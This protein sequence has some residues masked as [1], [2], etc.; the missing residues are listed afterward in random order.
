LVAALLGLSTAPTTPVAALTYRHDFGEPPAGAC[1]RADPVHLRAD[2]SGLILFDT[3]QFDLSAAHCEA[4]LATLNAHLQQDG[5]RLVS[6]HPQRWYLLGHAAPDLDTRALPA[7]RAR[8]VSA[9]PFTGRDA[10]LWTTRL[11]ELQ[12]LMHNHAVNQTRA[13]HGQ[14]G[15]NSVWLWG[16]GA[17]ELRGASP[18]T[19]VS[20]DN[21]CALGAAR[22]RQLPASAAAANAEQLLASLHRDDASLVVLEHCRD[23]AAY[24]D[25]SGWQSALSYLETHWFAPLLRALSAGRLQR[26]ELFPLNGVRYRIER[27]QLKY[28][29]KKT[30]PYTKAPGFRCDQAARV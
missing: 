20:A 19:R 26:L 2:R 12:M 27:R 16:G 25:F 14:V 10:A 18:Y 13:A 21:A 15:I 17:V 1:L 4:L 9:T 7:L 6:R 5:W 29:W 30:V 24:D 28:F 11:N 8:P 23:A 3:S 22:L